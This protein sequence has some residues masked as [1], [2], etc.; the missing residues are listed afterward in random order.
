MTKIKDGLWIWGQNAGSHHVNYSLPGENKMDSAT[1][2]KYLGIDRCCRVT[3]SAGPVPPFNAEAEKIKHLK[4]VVWS[5]IGAGGV[6]RNNNDQSDLD[7]ILRMAEIYPNVTGAVLDDFFASVEFAEQKIARHSI[8]SIKKMREK[9]HDFSKRKLDLWMVWYDYQLDYKVQDY[10][11]LCDVITMWTWKGC[12]LSKLD[13][14]IQKFVEK[15][16]G[17][18]HLA[19]CYFWNYGE[20]KAFTVEQMKYQLDRYYYW[21]KKGYIEGIVFCS[22]CCADLDLEAVELT[23]NWIKEFGD[24]IIN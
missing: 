3:N 16:S 22:N 2:C 12:E 23:R 20:D 24:D 6:K 15:T 10:L 11:E 1:G 4:E 21:L 7:E 14:N 18:R 13:E 8:E 17:K 9:L 19:G 5:A